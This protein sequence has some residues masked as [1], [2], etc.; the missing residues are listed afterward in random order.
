MTVTNGPNRAGDSAGTTAESTAPA[1]TRTART[2]WGIT[3]LVMIL[4]TVNFA[5]KAVLGIVARPLS[6][7]LGLSNADIGL[8]GSVFYVLF[9]VTGLLGGF[10]A[11]RVKIVWVLLVMALLWSLVQIPILLVGT[12]GAWSSAGSCSV[13]PRDRLHRS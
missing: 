8:L 2:A 6:E 9:V 3:F 1:G 4:Q 7:D 13:P 10:I 5:D 11:D 12:F